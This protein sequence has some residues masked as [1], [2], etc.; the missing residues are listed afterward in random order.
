M[1]C[2]LFDVKNYASYFWKPVIGTKIMLKLVLPFQT[3]HNF[4][5]N[6]RINVEHPV[7]WKLT[8]VSFL[9]WWEEGERTRWSLHCASSLPFLCSCIFTVWKFK[10]FFVT[11]ILRE[12]N[13]RIFTN[14]TKWK[15]S[16]YKT[17]K[18]FSRKIW[19]SEKFPN[20]HTVTHLC[21][22]GTVLNYVCIGENE[23]RFHFHTPW[24]FQRGKLIYHKRVAC[25]LDV[26]ILLL[27][28]RWPQ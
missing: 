25:L 13:L 4:T 28:R 24:S 22:C 8:W 12:I 11:Q 27:R 16:P 5:K 3:D 15:S 26:T 2:C 14:S 6:V 1:K 10:K 20:S 9:W 19:V 21:M 23:L 17:I 18:L 7:D